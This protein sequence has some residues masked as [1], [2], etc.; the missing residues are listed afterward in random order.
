MSSILY[1]DRID[2]DA[3]TNVFYFL[4]TFTVIRELRKSYTWRDTRRIRCRF[5]VQFMG[6][7]TNLNFAQKATG[8]PYEGQQANLLHIHEG[9]VSAMDS[10][11]DLFINTRHRPEWGKRTLRL[12]SHT[13]VLKW[14]HQE[15]E[16]F[17]FPLHFLNIP[18][19]FLCFLNISL[20]FPLH[21]L[22]YLY[23]SIIFSF[24]FPLHFLL[25]FFYISFY[26]ALSF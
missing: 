14:L 1:D 9:N 16:S 23:V 17:I 2:S 19:R 22:C 4:H 18:L 11:P 26:I 8:Y 21:F 20:T 3:W 13:Q 25:H 15:G 24:T 10:C 7:F 12:E 6:C 5:R